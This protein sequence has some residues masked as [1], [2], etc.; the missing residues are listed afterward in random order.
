M[1]KESQSAM[2]F[3]EMYGTEERCRE[4]LLKT[5]WPNGFRC[6]N[7][8][9]DFGY[10]LEKKQVYQCGVCKHQASI[11]SGTIFHNTHLPLTVW[12]YMIFQFSMSKNGCSATQLA[13]ELQR[14]YKT[15]WHV[16]HKIRFA[17]GQRDS[18]IT[19]AGLIEIDEAVLA[20]EARR[21]FKKEF[22]EQEE[23]QVKKPRGKRLGRLPADGKRKKDQIEVLVMAEAEQFHI[24]SIALKK[25]DWVDHSTIQEFVEKRVE[26]NKQY[27]RTDKRQSHDVLR[28]MGHDL[29]MKKSG[30]DGCKD[31]PVVH[32]VIHLLK[33]ALMSAYHGV[34]RKYLPGYLN[35]FAFRFQRKESVETK[36]ESLLRACIFSV[37]ITYAEQKL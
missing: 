20:P 9:H 1:I 33:H 10:W 26:D 4:K 14:P 22:P 36:P 34:S 25:M 12:F 24:G 21:P 29:V 5:R 27:F 8:E 6:P 28:S 17:M 3:H 16:L 32:R 35:E 31:L 13:A 23:T 19:L 15:I 11:T 18:Q 30:K 2:Q 7:C 37:P